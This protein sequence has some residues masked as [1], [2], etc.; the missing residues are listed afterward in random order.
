MLLLDETIPAPVY[1]SINTTIISENNFR[2]DISYNQPKFNEFT[3]W[4]PNGITFAANSTI[5]TYPFGIF[6]DKNNTIYITGQSMNRICIWKNDDINP[7]IIIPTNSW[8]Q[9]SSF[10]TS[11]GDIYTSSINSPYPI[12]KWMSNTSTIVAYADAQCFGVFVDVKN[13]LYFSVRDR[14][15]VLSKPL[16]A[17]STI[18]SIVAGTGISGN[19]ANKLNGPHGLFV[20]TNFDLYV[21][22][23]YN[24]RIQLFQSGQFNATTVAGSGSINTTIT[25]NSPISVV[26]DSNKYL[27]I[28]EYGSH[29]VVGSGPNG[30]QCIVGC[31]GSSGSS[32]NTLYRPS[33]MAFDS[34]GNIYVVDASN[35]RI[36]KFLRLNN[37]LSANPSYNQPKFCLNATWNPNATTLANRSIIGSS[38]YGMY[39]DKNN[40]IYAASQET[41]QILIWSNPTTVLRANLYSPRSIFVTMNGDIYVGDNSSIR[42]VSYSNSS[43][44]IVPVTSRCIGLFVDITNSI[45][46]SA[47]FQH[48]VLKKWLGDKNA[49]VMTSVAGTG[50]AGSAANQLNNPNGIFVDTNFDLY[51]ADRSNNRIQLFH[52]RQSNGITVAGNTSPNSTIALNHPFNVILDAN[53]YLFITDNGNNR[54][55]GSDETGFRCIVG[56]TGSSGSNSNQL[57]YPLSIAFDTSGNLYVVDRDNSRI[58]KFSLSTNPCYGKFVITKF[59]SS[60]YNIS[61]KVVMLQNSH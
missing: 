5:G 6:I 19:T 9:L 25:L 52:L 55:I 37:T 3:V 26:L 10:V 49:S 51:V 44:L 56:C 4:N 33:S 28:T 45:Y 22:D 39:I 11:H 60:I 48:Q 46:C 18:L 20:D 34:F 40:T 58:Q 16:S 50:S 27:F 43:K 17:Q 53:K 59:S 29:R 35:N 23:S 36:Q 2:L 31:T 47:D 24:N 30:F 7:T 8:Y 13:I 1:T 42:Q 14:H 57:K 15:K 21:A 41:G 32:F 61:L 54:I 12:N 38:P